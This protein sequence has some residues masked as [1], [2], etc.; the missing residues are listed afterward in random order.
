MAERDPV[1]QPGRPL[2]LAAA[3]EHLAVFKPAG[4]H[5]F[6]SG[7]LADWLLQ[8]RPALA[9]VGP[10][11]QPALVHRLDRDTAGLMLAAASPGAYA[12]LRRAF[13]EGAIDKR[14]LA[15]I[16]GEL[17]RPA[18]VD[19]PLGAR[20][21]RSRRVAV[22]AGRQRLRGVRPAHTTIEPLA[23][24]AGW[25][26]CAVRIRTGMRHQIRAHLAHLGHPVAGDGLYGGAPLPGLTGRF[27]L[28]AWRLELAAGHAAGPLAH[29]CGLD[30]G[31]R[32]VAR[33]LGFAPELVDQ[34]DD[35]R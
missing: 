22:A 27:F 31:L 20:Y 23:R 19:R 14:Y 34:P 25:T 9:A 15:L 32:R 33:A 11:E 35:K 28:H 26:L 4:M 2:L 30:A 5:A 21:R 18:V 6:G 17:E 3:A 16:G 29:R 7:S 8:Q 24:S 10:A 13:A 1:P 12:A